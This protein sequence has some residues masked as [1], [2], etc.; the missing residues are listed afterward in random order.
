MTPSPHDSAQQSPAANSP[1]FKPN[2]EAKIGSRSF[3]PSQAVPACEA[4]TGSDMCPPA[5][6]AAEQVGTFGISRVMDVARE[7]EFEQQ[8]AMADL[9]ASRGRPRDAIAALEPALA[10]RPAHV[11]ALCLK[12]GCLATIDSKA[13]VRREWP[14]QLEWQWPARHISLPGT[15][16]LL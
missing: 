16:A 13:Q 4:G 8:L 14:E 2:E 6:L 11:E 15:A 12:G 7:S 10:L 9:L 3:S 1:P 5:S